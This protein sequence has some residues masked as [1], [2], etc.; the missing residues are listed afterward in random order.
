MNAQYKIDLAN[1]DAEVSV[2]VRSDTGKKVSIRTAGLLNRLT[3]SG[4]RTI[5][6]E[7]ALLGAH[8]FVQNQDNSWVEVMP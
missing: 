7:M 8:L 4:K 2:E 3:F 6:K 5:A 1:L